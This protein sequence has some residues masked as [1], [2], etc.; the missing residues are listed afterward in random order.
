MSQL[1]SRI[2]ACMSR[3][4]WKWKIPNFKASYSSVASETSHN[5]HIVRILGSFRP[6]KSFSSHRANSAKP[7]SRKR[8]FHRRN[9]G[10]NQEFY[11]LL[12]TRLRLCERARAWY[13]KHISSN[14]EGSQKCIF[15][16]LC[17]FLHLC[18]CAI[19]LHDHFLTGQQQLEE[20]GIL[21]VG[22]KMT[23]LCV[24]SVSVHI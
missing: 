24:K 7:P 17:T 19:L 22:T 11:L 3:G 4:K 8:A 12:Y 20:L 1:N 14:C 13:S 16:A 15:H 21:I 6:T 5:H 2:P 10:V 18:T 9:I 23:F